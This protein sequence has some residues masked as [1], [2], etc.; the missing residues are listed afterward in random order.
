[1]VLFC[2][3]CALMGASVFSNEFNHR[4]LP[5]LLAQPVPRKNLWRIKML[6][7]L[8]ALLSAD[9]LF[10]LPM[11]A[12]M[13]VEELPQRDFKLAFSL[14]IPIGCAFCSGPWLTLATRNVIGGVV[15]SLAIP[16]SIAIGVVFAQDIFGTGQLAIY[17]AVAFPVYW[18]LAYWRGYARFKS[19]E[20]IESIAH[21]AS[22]PFQIGVISDR[23]A[24]R[25]LPKSHGPFRA[26]VKK[27][28]R[29]Q[30]ASYLLAGVFCIV[31][32]AVLGLKWARP[33]INADYFL[34]WLFI[35]ISMAA[36]TIGAVSVAEERH[37]GLHDWHLTLPPS[38]LKQ[39]L[40]KILVTFAC[41]LVLA[42]LLPVA[43]LCAAQLQ[44]DALHDFSSMPLFIVIVF[45]LTVTAVAIYASSISDNTL[46]AVLGGLGLCGAIWAG[47]V[48][49]FPVCAGF[50]DFTEAAFSKGLLPDNLMTL[51]WQR[52]LYFGASLTVGTMIL[53]AIILSLAYANFRF[54]GRSPR[55]LWGHALWFFL[56]LSL[57]VTLLVNLFQYWSACELA[58]SS[59]YAL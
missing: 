37:L 19:F 49:L 35:Y 32:L 56:P 6:A 47:V 20:A 28:L 10:A 36:I 11:L 25:L 5:L 24:D 13:S 48:A 53:L 39:W 44:F 33:G 55:Q 7:L 8:A 29:L 14:L 2:I 26:L 43:L 50:F 46:R 57:L 18:L 45:P 1:M 12:R 59:R 41:S 16:I 51:E 30:Q 4:T 17:F 40:I 31:W 27:E 3:A 15:F 21:E 38:R 58:A 34:P 22:A 52:V 54:A 42:V 23:F 9:I